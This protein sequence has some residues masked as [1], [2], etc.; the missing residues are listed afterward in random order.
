MSKKSKR[1]FAVGE[2]RP[3]VGRGCVEAV[4][5]MWILPPKDISKKPRPM[6]RLIDMG[7]GLPILHTDIAHS[8]FAFRSA[9][10]LPAWKRLTRVRP[11]LVKPNSLEVSLPRDCGAPELNRRALDEACRYLGGL[12]IDV[13]YK[14]HARTSPS[15][16]V[17]S[18]VVDRHSLPL[19]LSFNIGLQEPFVAEV[20]P[21]Q[22]AAGALRAVVDYTRLRALQ[23]TAN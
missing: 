10:E 23:A 20:S 14:E 17:L 5:G 19:E 11:S 12:G 6:V 16:T 18:A 9:D 2:I 7:D 22:V 13:A 1:Q 15:R 3:A 8:A 4:G 21:R